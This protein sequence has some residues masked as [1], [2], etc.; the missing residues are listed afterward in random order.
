MSC[1]RDL[2]A[3]LQSTVEEQSQQ[4]RVLRGTCMCEHPPLAA[5]HV[6]SSPR[7][8]SPLQDVRPGQ[9]GMTFAAQGTS[10]GDATG[11]GR[12]MRAPSRPAMQQS[13]LVSLLS[14]TVE[15]Q[16]KVTS[17]LLIA[18]QCPSLAGQ[19]ISTQRESGL[20]TCPTT[21]YS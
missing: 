18:C 13:L 1:L 9:R 2:V 11:V 17:V 16:K 20:G 7:A 5:R 6:H 12:A 3:S 8:R 15:E 19:P 14:E 10:E 21:S 4:I